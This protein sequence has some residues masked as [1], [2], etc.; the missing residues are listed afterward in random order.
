MRV[1]IS[2]FDNK[3]IAKMINFS[4]DNDCQLFDTKE[5]SA[6]GDNKEWKLYV[7]IKKLVNDQKL[8]PIYIEQLERA[9]KE[10]NIKLEE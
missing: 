9:Y 10:L 8:K 6:I 1:H 7:F 2:Q 5:F 3:I 4:K